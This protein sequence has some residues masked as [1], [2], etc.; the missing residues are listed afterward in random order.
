M[1][2]RNVVLVVLVTLVS[3][4]FRARSDS[5][6]QDDQVRR[7]IPP[8]GAT[9]IVARALGQKYSEKRGQP[10]VV[11]NRPGASG[12]IAADLVAKSAGD[13]YTLLVS[14]ATSTA[15]AS[16][17]YPNLPY[18]ASQGPHDRHR[19]RFVTG[20]AGHTPV[21]AAENFP[22]V[23]S[24]RESEQPGIDVRRRRYGLERPPD[25]RAPQ[26]RAQ[27]ENDTRAV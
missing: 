12:T 11:D 14:S 8:S 22:R 27:S 21:T 24:V 5:P 25:R 19:R 13:G 3:L 26:P 15:I 16:S 6:D 23:C 7:S 18:Q 1:A 17:L 20:I 9:D 10:V 2:L 4:R